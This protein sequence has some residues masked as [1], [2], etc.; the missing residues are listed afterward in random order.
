MA[1]ANRGITI[2]WAD[3]LLYLS[4]NILHNLVKPLRVLNNR[5]EGTIYYS[6]FVSRSRPSSAIYLSISN[7]G[8]SSD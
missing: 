8:T 5:E 7:I 6:S 3:G 4:D 2:E 1:V